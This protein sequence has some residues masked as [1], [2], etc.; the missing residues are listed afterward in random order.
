MQDA[1]SD[2]ICMVDGGASKGVVD[3]PSAYALSQNYPNPFNPSLG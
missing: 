1:F 2:A 3:A